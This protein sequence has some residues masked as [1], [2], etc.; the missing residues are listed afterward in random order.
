MFIGI[1]PRNIKGPLFARLLKF[2]SGTLLQLSPKVLGLD[3][4]G[5]TLGD[6]LSRHLCK[7][8]NPPKK[9]RWVCHV[10]G[11]IPLKN[12][13]N[14]LCYNFFFVTRSLKPGISFI[15]T[16]HLA[17]PRPYFRCPEVTCGSGQ[18]RANDSDETHSAF[19]PGEG[20][21][22]EGFVTF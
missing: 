12:I 6:L 11:S 13:I 7:L 15:L 2:P 17:S 3:P 21:N 14:E 9:Q 20:E 1:L 5:S 22:T 8:D 19:A 10:S 4:F 16:E 18:G